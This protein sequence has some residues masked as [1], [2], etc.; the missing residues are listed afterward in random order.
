MEIQVRYF[1]SIRERRGLASESVTT[2]AATPADLYRALSATH[3]F[4]LP[5]HLV[6]FA[7]NGEFVEADAELVSGDEICLIP[8]VAGG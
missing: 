6:R 7:R 4:S 8:P 5:E 1:A 2:D 3:G